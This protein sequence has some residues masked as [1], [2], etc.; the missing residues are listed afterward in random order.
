V[1]SMVVFPR[2]LKFWD[3][4]CNAGFPEQCSRTQ[5]EGAL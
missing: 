4:A 2:G 3:A 1:C 5:R